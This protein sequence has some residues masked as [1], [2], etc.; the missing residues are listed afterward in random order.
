MASHGPFTIWTDGYLAYAFTDDEENASFSE[1]DDASVD[2]FYSAVSF[3]TYAALMGAEVGY[4]SNF[5]DSNE[6]DEDFDDEFDE[7]FDADLAYLV[8][9][10]FDDTTEDDGEY[11][12]DRTAPGLEFI[13]GPLPL[14]VTNYADGIS[15]QHTGLLSQFRPWLP[16]T[17]VS[18]LPLGPF[19]VNEALAANTNDNERDGIEFLGEND[20]S[21][22]SILHGRD[23]PTYSS[24]A[25]RGGSFAA[26][27][28]A[29][30]MPRTRRQTAD[31][32]TSSVV[33]DPF[34]FPLPAD[35]A[36]AVASSSA[37]VLPSRPRT[38][39]G[40]RTL[41]CPWDN[42]PESV[43]RTSQSHKRRRSGEAGPSGTTLPP[44]ADLIASVSNIG[45]S[46]S[47]QLI[48]SQFSGSSNSTA[49]RTTISPSRTRRGEQI[50]L[51]DDLFGSDDDVDASVQMVNLVDVD[52]PQTAAAEGA[53]KDNASSQKDEKAS[54]P[55]PATE[56]S[57]TLVRL[58]AQQ[59]VI[60]MDNIVNLTATHCGHIF[61]GECLHA[62][63]SMDSSRHICPICRTKV[64]MRAPNMSATRLARSVFPL[65]L[66]MRARNQ[67]G[68]QL[69]SSY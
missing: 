25:Q 58:S 21:S 20:F 47:S 13:P 64:E 67:K 6:L 26:N 29:D 18:Q 57:K 60:C 48:D 15:N 24:S 2:S 52:R 14:P 50:V 19:S 27:L 55:G 30:G 42:G 65:Q 22:P 59:C 68:K 63:L 4:T 46:S 11:Q 53:G 36:T 9:N 5:S 31:E 45:R 43:P 7:D 23:S 49:N 56:S 12:P 8:D 1:A 37:S 32:R 62:S 10:P 66:K 51:Y 38:R 44:I 17:P 28:D 16:A 61:C 35:P 39:S 33:A 34:P 54:A 3:D 40:S 69:D 41:T